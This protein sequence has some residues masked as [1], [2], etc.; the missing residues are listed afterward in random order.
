[1]PPKLTKEIITAA[2]EGYESQKTRINQQIAEL[3]SRLTGGLAK[4]T[5]E[6]EGS[7][8]KRRKFSAA[9]RRRMVEAQKAR[10]AKIKG[11]PKPSAPAK[12]PTKPKRKISA[13]GRKAMA[14]ASSKRWAAVKAA[15][16]KA[17][18][19][20]SKKAAFKKTAAKKA[21][22]KEAT[23]EAPTA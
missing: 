3:R 21:V 16:E 10:W 15:K 11:E 19:P 5:A 13:A 17:A 4:P 22:V 23:A 20:A 1:M 12:A 7:P 14:E 8:S 9:A 2:I 18:K 6:S